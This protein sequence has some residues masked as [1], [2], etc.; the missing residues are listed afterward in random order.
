LA[1][2]TANG[3][4]RLVMFEAALQGLTR[5]STSVAHDASH[6]IA[7][8][9]GVTSQ[10]LLAVQSFRNLMS[11]LPFVNR[12]VEPMLR[13]L[14]N[15][16]LD[17]LAGFL[18][19]IA[20]TIPDPTIRDG[21]ERAADLMDQAIRLRVGH[22]FSI[23]DLLEKV[24]AEVGHRVLM[25]TYV[26][27]TQPVLNEAVNHAANPSGPTG[28]AATAEQHTRALVDRWRQQG[29]AAHSIYEQ[30]AVRAEVAKVI[31]NIADIAG[32]VASPSDIGVAVAQIISVGA[33]GIASIQYGTAAGEN[34]RVL[35][36]TVEAVDQAD[37]LAFHLES[38]GIES[39]PTA[40]QLI[41]TADR[42]E[43]AGQQLRMHIRLVQTADEYGR[44]L[45]QV[46]QT[47]QA[48]QF[49]ALDDLVP[50]L[51]AADTAFST[52]LRASAAPVL[53][54][55]SLTV[56]Q[57]AALYAARAQF[58]AASAELYGLL[59]AYL[60]EPTNQDNRTQLI[61]QARIA[62]EVAQSYS[63][64]VTDLAATRI[65]GASPPLVIV[66]AVTWPDR[67]IAGQPFDL[68]IQLLNTGSTPAIDAR[69]RIRNSGIITVDQFLIFDRLPGN[70]SMTRTLTLRAD[71]PGQAVLSVAASTVA[72]QT[73]TTSWGINVEAPTS[74]VSADL[75]IG[76]IGLTIVL[77]VA[78][79]TGLTVLLIARR[80][81]KARQ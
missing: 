40:G 21:A 79:V 26:T 64:T 73:D 65:D 68:A 49:P 55:Q 60:I 19:I 67:V 54:T 81:S 47:V 66:V 12:L 25:R 13:M 9:I 42:R 8:I 27:K 7:G 10:M 6:S 5:V 32:A 61:D 78:V 51:L 35:A 31:G 30:M 29:E 28:E 34:L 3:F 20:G 36:G 16:V 33:K 41:L 14:E 69:A 2:Q 57:R 63:T 77:G 59:I 56:Q 52:Q 18:Q 4:D 58:D 17:I 71:Q 38:A 50:E 39:A 76:P 1:R 15:K 22:G 62:A 11:K 53:A 46:R 75:P 37:Q 45:D 74:R 44:L 72:G 24:L 23:A 70:E 80:R 43:A 48:D